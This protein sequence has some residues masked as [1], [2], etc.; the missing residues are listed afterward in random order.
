MDLVR[1]RPLNP[2]SA[3]GALSVMRFPN[4][5]PVL[6]TLPCISFPANVQRDPHESQRYFLRGLGRDQTRLQARGIGLRC[7]HA[8]SRL[9]NRFLGDQYFRVLRPGGLEVLLARPLLKS[10]RNSRIQLEKRDQLIA[11]GALK[12]QTGGQLNLTPR[13]DSAEYSAYVVG[14]IASSILEDG[15]SVA[16][17]CKWTLRVIRD[18]EIRMIE[19]IVAFRSQRNLRAFRHLEGLLQRQPSDGSAELVAYEWWDGTATQIKVVFRIER[20]I[21]VKF[22]QRSMEVITS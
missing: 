4:P 13:A 17:Q 16:S 20:S 15:I 3:L 8:G 19:Q 7:G 22:E 1:N 18:C 9:P 6:L 2:V 14:E 5:W 10:R 11:S 12:T 21:P